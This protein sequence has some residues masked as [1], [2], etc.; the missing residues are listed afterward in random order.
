MNTEARDLGRQSGNKDEDKPGQ[1]IFRK[2]QLPS[3]AV[4]GCR[5]FLIEIVTKPK[6]STVSPVAMGSI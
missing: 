2:S 3:A 4:G 5:T 6:M 1:A